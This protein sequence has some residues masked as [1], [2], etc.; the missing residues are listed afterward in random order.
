MKLIAQLLSLISNPLLMSI[1]APFLIIYHASKDHFYAMKWSILSFFFI[2]AIALF[3]FYGV[4]KGYFSNFDISKRE[5]RK[6]LFI[7]LSIMTA[8]YFNIVILFGG[9]PVLIVAVLGFSIG[10]LLTAVVN[11]F[12]KASIHV[13]IF[14]ACVLSIAILYGENY[15]YGILAIPLVAWSRVYTKRHTFSEV[16]VGGAIGSVFTL[17]T[18]VI[19]RYMLYN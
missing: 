9:H 14:T 2:I 4:W 7:F 19:G 10:I 17:I 1:P 3:V 12:I 13:A 15:L 16:I 11:S 18:F 8:I 6:P 5:E